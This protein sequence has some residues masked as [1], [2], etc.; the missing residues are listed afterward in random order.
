[1][2]LLFDAVHLGTNEH[3][4]RVLDRRNFDEN[5]VEAGRGYVR[6]Y[7]E[8]VHYV[9]RLYQAGKNPAHDHY[10]QSAQAATHEK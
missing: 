8:F 1:M 6:A 5:D 10:P 2:G 3:F 9:E 4:K 7:V